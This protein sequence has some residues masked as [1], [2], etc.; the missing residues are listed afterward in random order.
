MLSEF[1]AQIVKEFY[2]H[3]ILCAFFIVAIGF[4]WVYLCNALYKRSSYFLNT[5]KTFFIRK[6]VKYF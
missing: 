6:N 3:Y 2:K 1:I 4:L 5:K